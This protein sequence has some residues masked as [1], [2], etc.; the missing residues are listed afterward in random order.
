MVMAMAM[1]CVDRLIDSHLH[2]PT[3]AAAAAGG[4]AGG[5]DGSSAAGREAPFLEAQ[6]KGISDL[7]K[8]LVI[9]CEPGSRP[10]RL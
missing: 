9:A 3:I 2:I 5:G 4:G 10:A 8:G 1:G 6:A 7:E